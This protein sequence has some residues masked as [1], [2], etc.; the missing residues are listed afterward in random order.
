V[1][2][3]DAQLLAADFQ[4]AG[5][6]IHPAFQFPLFLAQM[7]RAQQGANQQQDEKAQERKLAEL[8]DTAMRRQP[9]KTA[10]SRRRH[11]RSKTSDSFRLAVGAKDILLRLKAA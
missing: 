11:I 7:P 4:L 10:P 5:A 2:E 8:K 1:S 3:L 9:G 6:L